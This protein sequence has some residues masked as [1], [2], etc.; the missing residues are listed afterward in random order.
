MLAAGDPVARAR[1]LARTFAESLEDCACA[2]YRTDASE[3]GAVVLATVGEISVTPKTV[4]PLS[5]ISSAWPASNAATV[6]SGSRLRREDFAHLNVNRT[7]ESI[8][9]LPIDMVD[10]SVA[11][12]EAVPGGV[13]ELISFSAV[14]E[15]A[16]LEGLEPIRSLGSKALHAAGQVEQERMESLNS[17]H[18]MSQLY[19][20]EKSLNATLELEEVNALVPDKVRTMLDCQAVH[21]WLFDGDVLRLI[22]TSGAD[23]TVKVQ[24]TQQPG[25]GYVA[26]MAEEGEVVL[27]DDPADER[28]A[29]RN[30]FLGLRPATPPIRSALLV[31][32]MQDE[33]EVGVLEAINK[34][35]GEPFDEDDV[36]FFSTM[37]ET[38]ASALKNA[39]LMHAE[40]KLEILETLVHVSSEI[41]STL[42]LD[43]L[44]QIIVNSPQTVLPYDRC[45]IALDNKGALQLK[46]VSGRSALPIGDVQVD[47]LNDL[48]RWLGLQP[49][50]LY[51]KESEDEEKQFDLPRAVRH[52]FE[53]TGNR[54]L[55]SMPL[56]DDQG[57][58]GLLIY[59]STDP[60]FLDLPHIE[61]IKI[62]AGQATVAIRNALL[63]REVPLISLLEPLARRK[64]ALFRNER[65]RR[66]AYGVTAA[67]LIL[68]LLFCPWPMRIGG[69]AVIAPLH[70]VNV[71][72][73]LEGNVS[74]V[75]VREGQ[76]VN[77]GQA[78]GALNDWQWRADL[79]TAEA[80]Y[81]TAQLTMEEDLARG[82]A[83]AGADRAQAD[84]MRA[85][86]ERARMH[87]D[88]A[89]LRSPIH[90]VVTT[91]NLENSV[92][93]HL[94]AGATFA[95]VLD[96]SSAVVDIAVDQ[97][98]VRYI[99]PG[100][101]ASV[102]L[103]SFP[104]KIL[105]GSVELVSPQTQ[106]VNGDRTFVVR[107][108]LQ[109]E[110]GLLRAGMNGNAKIF[111]GYRSV[112]Y[113]LFRKPAFWLWHTLWNW[114]GW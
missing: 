18:R 113:V 60:D 95:Q 89:Q 44:M 102:K 79:S 80:R 52:H 109:N 71:D 64:R 90:G 98:D 94:D 69:H 14:L 105:R 32:L 8:A 104:Q 5:V 62:L 75:Y 43:R 61:M 38:V 59:E 39:T 36:F 73:P 2:V 34:A 88:D 65:S 9:Y 68:F 15:T 83:R 96:L 81:R 28:L 29:P 21:L 85:E 7:V 74:A 54:G 42:R 30:S 12:D 91:P 77:A 82:S 72:T 53:I 20:L 37:A 49:N 110:Q 63:Y 35:G 100:Q 114:I 103:D 107:V 13:I 51:L 10:D 16:E 78:L 97:G 111:V 84:L 67:I 3:G 26:D 31:P 1:I 48:I 99:A 40:R 92:G 55:Y 108:P 86:L 46:A 25:E 101:E 17:I 57:R 93:L 112:G 66:I 70:T 33:A 19:D 47:Q 58:V 41:T 11:P 106:V 56:S 27:I 23:A 24:M 45:S 50:V 87:M 76:R 4:L 22:S 6:L